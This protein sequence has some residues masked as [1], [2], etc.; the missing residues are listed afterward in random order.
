[1]MLILLGLLILSPLTVAPLKAAVFLGKAL[2]FPGN[3]DF[4]LLF[5]LQEEQQIRQAYQE[6]YKP[7]PIP[8]SQATHLHLNAILYMN[9]N[10]WVIWV[11]GEKISPEIPCP[12]LTIHEVSALHLRCIWHHTT[13]DYEIELRANQTFTP[14]GLREP[15]R[16][17]G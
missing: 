10:D 12:S 5:T 7:Q 11:N 15:Q 13:Q 6:F 1:M 3:Q 4:S 16:K 9:Q 2:D 17:A 14:Y 8:I